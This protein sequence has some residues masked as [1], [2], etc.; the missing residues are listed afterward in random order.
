MD[1]AQERAASLLNKT[2]AY[3]EVG[4]NTAPLKE[5]G[6]FRDRPHLRASPP[7]QKLS[8]GAAATA[9]RAKT[10]RKVDSRSRSNAAPRRPQDVS[11]ARYTATS[12]TRTIGFIKEVR[13]R[14]TAISAPDRFKLGTFKSVVAAFR[15]ISEAWGRGHA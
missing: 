2:A 5:K 9:A 13:G 4:E 6:K 12:G 15:A 1:G 7:P 14:F 10:S 3:G 11:G 8:P